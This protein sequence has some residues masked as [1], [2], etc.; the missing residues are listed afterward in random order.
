LTALAQD[1]V[2]DRVVEYGSSLPQGYGVIRVGDVSAALAERDVVLLDVREVEEYAAG[3]IPGAFNVPIRTL[4]ENLALLPDLD[5]EIIV[6]C[7][8][9]ARATLAMTS[10]QLLGYTNVKTFA[11]GYDAWVGEDLPTT[12]DVFMPETG[13]APTFDSQL[14]AAVDSYLANLPQGYGLV[15]AT[16]LAAELVENPPMLLDVRSADEWA[17]GYIEGAQHL[18][19]DDFVSNLS[20]LPTDRNTPLV[21]YC[22]SGYRGGVATVMLNVLG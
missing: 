8:G 9:G 13:T 21:I 17:G 16:N 5:A 11:G 3:H 12:T 7:K 19:I 18:W 2:L 20:Q 4:T 22:A 1:V 15:S 6:V 10:L 14:F